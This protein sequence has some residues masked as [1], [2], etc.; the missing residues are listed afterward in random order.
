MGKISW[1]FELFDFT[2]YL[3][4]TTSKKREKDT[5][6]SFFDT[7]CYSEVPDQISI[8]GFAQV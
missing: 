7:Y 1:K 2:V 4:N 8:S 5:D 6:A 3:P